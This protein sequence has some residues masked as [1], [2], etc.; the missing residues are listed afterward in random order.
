M[1]LIRGVIYEEITIIFRGDYRL[2]YAHFGA[3]SHAAFKG[4]P[5]SHFVALVMEN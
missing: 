4:A 2:I 3:P 1:M 5:I